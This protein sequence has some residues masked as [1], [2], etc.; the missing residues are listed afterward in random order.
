MNAVS[1][2][3]HMNGL[4]DG[5]WSDLAGLPPGAELFVE[6]L[7]GRNVRGRLRV[8]DSTQITLAIGEDKIVW[9]PWDMVRCLKRI[10]VSMTREDVEVGLLVGG[11]LRARCKIN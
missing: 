11:S 5:A 10:N 9:V 4:Q 3:P 1:D 7:Y 2:I 8:F 6:T